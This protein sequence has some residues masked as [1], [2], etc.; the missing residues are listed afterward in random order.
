MGIGP[1]TYS[2]GSWTYVFPFNDLPAKLGIFDPKRINGLR[3]KSKTFHGRF[4]AS[5]I[6]RIAAFVAAPLAT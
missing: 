2:L 4:F 6:M 5:L 1:T 3:R